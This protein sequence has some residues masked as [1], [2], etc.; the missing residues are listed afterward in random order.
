MQMKLTGILLTLLTVSS[1]SAFSKEK[2]ESNSHID[3]TPLQSNQHFYIGAKAG[4]NY[5]DDAC[6]E[7]DEDC[8]NYGLGYG[9]YSGYQLL[10]WLAVEAGINNFNKVDAT[11][12]DGHVSADIWATDVSAVLKY[13]LTNELSLYTR[14]GGIYSSIDKESTYSDDSSYRG[15]SLL[16]AVG[17]DYAFSKRWSMRLEYQ[18]VDG[19]GDNSNVL[20][21]DMSY[22]SIGLA[23]HFGQSDNISAIP[24]PEPISQPEP[25]PVVKVVDVSL[26]S[27]ALFDSNSYEVKQSKSL[28]HWAEELK[29]YKENNIVITGHTDSTGT[30]KYNQKLSERR[31]QAVADYILSAG[32]EY[33]NLTVKGLGEA[34]PIAS[35]KTA[36]GRKKNR[37]VD[38]VVEA[39]SVTEE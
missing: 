36:E 39:K 15:W 8:D 23:Y 16:G 21:A 4:F 29:K 22:A 28:K 5:L 31:A 6:G 20:Q 14:L 12:S 26:N 24:T 2:N 33:N 17:A 32:V 13:Y 10:P 25:E 7:N 19:L 9:L 1:P 35:N 34:Q 3:D 27:N 38:I 30:E 18:Y 11:Y 37:R